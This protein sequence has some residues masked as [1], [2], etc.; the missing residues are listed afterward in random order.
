MADFELSYKQGNSLF[1]R[2]TPFSKLLFV[3]SVSFVA[4]F[5]TNLY[6]GAGLF[7][8]CFL[9]A[10]FLTPPERTAQLETAL[11]RT[12]F[13]LRPISRAERSAPER[14]RQTFRTSR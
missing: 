13:S 7:V 4:I 1:H 9:F 11:Q 6:V 14:T 8:F 3:L 2:M 5:N 12:T 10:A